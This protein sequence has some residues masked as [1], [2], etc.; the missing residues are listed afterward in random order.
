MKGTTQTQHTDSPCTASERVWHDVCNSTSNQLN[1][2]KMRTPMTIL[3][4]ALQVISVAI[5]VLD[6]STEPLAMV[7]FMAST[8]GVWAAQALEK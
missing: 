6:S 8:F 1:N 3:M 7:C 4:T 2:I 5:A